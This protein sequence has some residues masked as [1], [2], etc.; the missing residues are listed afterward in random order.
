VS[1]SIVGMEI[2]S[3]ALAAWQTLA[4]RYD[5]P[6]ATRTASTLV[7]DRGVENVVWPRAQ[8][9]T[10]GVGIVGFAA[11]RLARKQHTCSR[12]RPFTVIDVPRS[13]PE[14]TY[15]CRRPRMLRRGGDDDTGEVDV[16]NM[17]NIRQVPSLVLGGFRLRSPPSL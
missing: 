1:L 11:P 14:G 8:G 9:D 17:M 15:T 12:T 13:S 7:I 10:A 16:E 6:R 5:W 3:Y 2:L 4:D